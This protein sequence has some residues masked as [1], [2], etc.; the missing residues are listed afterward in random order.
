MPNAYPVPSQA[1]ILALIKYA[2]HISTIDAAAFF[3]QRGVKRSHRY[4]LTVASHGGKETFNVPVMGYRNSPAYVQRMI[5]RILR[6]FRHF[7]RA[8][9]DDIVIFSTSLEKHVKHLTQVFKALHTMNIHLAPDKAY[10]GYPSV[11]LL[12][13]RVNALG[14]AT[15][16][17]K[18][19]AIKKLEFP[20]TLAA[21]DKYLGLTGYLKQYVP[22]Y[23]AIAK[24]LQ[25]RKTYLYQKSRSNNG[26]SSKHKTNAARLRLEMPTPQ[27]LHLYYQLQQMFARPSMLHHHDPKRQLYVDLDASKEWGLAAHVYHVKEPSTAGGLE[28][29]MRE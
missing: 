25:K 13:P 3:Y 23:T 24:P 19:V 18:L 9:V 16:D 27:E 17:E 26:I 4:R 20:R 14:L 7:C 5:D 2:S 21:S 10:P 6:P 11:H 15:A 12:G 1:D 29:L 8:Y 22:Y 28:C